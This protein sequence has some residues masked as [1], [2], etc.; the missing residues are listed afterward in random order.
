[1]NTRLL[2]IAPISQPSTSAAAAAVCVDS[3]RRRTSAV[4]PAASSASWTRT[5]L[6]C[7]ALLDLRY[8]P[9]IGI[10]DQ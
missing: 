1:M 8:R 2:A 9:R 5:L 6:G 7:I 3:G 4:T 10:L